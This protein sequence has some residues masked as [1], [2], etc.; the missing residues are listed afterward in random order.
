MRVLCRA[1]TDL[2]VL[3]EGKR[4]ANHEEAAGAVRHA[5]L[6]E[7]IPVTMPVSRG[8][9]T[10]DAP[11]PVAV[12]TENAVEEP[13]ASRMSSSLTDQAE[14]LP[15]TPPTSDGFSGNGGGAVNDSVAIDDPAPGGVGDQLQNGTR[16]RTHKRDSHIGR[17]VI[18]ALR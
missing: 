14:R 12:P 5:M 9:T 1:T 10:P 18:Q 4:A 7:G 8:R 16:V 17:N 15:A 2:A 3:T 11:L 13:D 6:C